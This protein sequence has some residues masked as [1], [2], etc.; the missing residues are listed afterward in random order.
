MQPLLLTLLLVVLML[1]P[2]QT[3]HTNKEMELQ[4]I[5]IEHSINWRTMEWW[6]EM[7]I[8]CSVQNEPSPWKMSSQYFFLYFLYR[9]QTDVSAESEN[10]LH[11]FWPISF[12]W[13][14]SFQLPRSVFIQW[15]RFKW[16]EQRHRDIVFDCLQLLNIV[17]IHQQI[18]P[19]LQL[20]WR[21]IFYC[22]Q[23]CQKM[24]VKGKKIEKE[25]GQNS[26][27]INEKHQLWQW[28]RLLSIP[29]VSDMGLCCDSFSSFSTNGGGLCYYLRCMC[30]C[31][32]DARE[33]FHFFLLSR[34]V[35]VVS[36]RRCVCLYLTT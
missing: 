12:R 16:F 10:L 5:L 4:A 6:Y 7:E 24:K 17:T 15:R 36:V 13:E 18:L 8:D 31:V 23:R 20:F 19:R 33:I 1:P 22:S 29:L 27:L 28:D 21:C 35:M 34:F 3:M 9:I 2:L 30:L 25:N 26:K 32:C 14:L 11:S